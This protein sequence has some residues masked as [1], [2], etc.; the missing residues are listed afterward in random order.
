MHKVSK[1]KTGLALAVGLWASL[2]SGC[3]VPNSI[4]GTTPYPQQNLEVIERS[5]QAYRGLEARFGG[6]VEATA[7]NSK[8]NVTQ[9]SIV[10]LDLDFVGSPM[11]SNDFKGII[12]GYYTGYLDPVIYKNSLMTVVGPI[13]GYQDVVTD[14]GTRRLIQMKVNGFQPWGKP[15][16]ANNLDQPEVALQ[17]DSGS[18]DSGIGQ[19]RHPQPYRPARHDAKRSS[20]NNSSKGNSPQGNSPQ[21][22]ASQ[23]NTSPRPQQPPMHNMPQGHGAPP[24]HQE[25]AHNAPPP[26]EE[27]PHSAPP[28]HR[29]PPPP[30]K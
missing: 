7:Y 21:G 3:S 9:I 18:F 15:A 6:I 14:K 1:R 10:V 30:K 8:T 13:L 17:A 28:E 11:L 12:L 4:K 22:N 20:W 29:P 23:G 26:H 27:H 19:I 2:L 5:P 24:A 16:Q 25:R